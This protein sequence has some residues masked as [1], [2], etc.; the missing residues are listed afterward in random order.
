MQLNSIPT[1]ICIYILFR[2]T[3]CG[4]E[5]KCNLRSKKMN[6]ICPVPGR[7]VLCVRL[8]VKSKINYEAKIRVSGHNDASS[9]MWRVRSIHT[10]PTHIYSYLQSPSSHRC[11]VNHVWYTP[12][13]DDEGGGWRGGRMEK[14]ARV[15][16]ADRYYTFIVISVRCL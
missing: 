4:R 11:A 14:L 2:Y 10:S 3:I 6:C 9:N 16:T 8:N 7:H 12:Q 13:M 5:A 1:Y 15:R